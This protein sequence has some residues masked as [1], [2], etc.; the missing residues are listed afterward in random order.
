M[1]VQASRYH[2]QDGTHEDEAE[3][4]ILLAGVTQ[5][6]AVEGERVNGLER[7]RLELLAGIAR[8]R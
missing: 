7:A 1:A 5:P 6:R 4:I 2:G 8:D 3:R